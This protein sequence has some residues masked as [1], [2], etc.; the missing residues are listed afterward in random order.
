[1]WTF[2]RNQGGPSLAISALIHSVALA[3]LAFYKFSTYVA[4]ESVAVETV[5]ADERSQQQFDQDLSIDTRVSTSLST[6]SGG[7]VTTSIGSAATQA[8]GQAKIASSEVMK[9][10]ALSVATI[11][12]ISIPGVGELGMDLGEGEVKGE[13]G[14]RV[15]GYGAAMGRMT[16]ELFR[17]MRKEPVTV[18]WLFDASIS[19][20]DDRKE[21]SANFNKIYEELRIAQTEAKSRNMKVSPLDTMICSFGADVKKLLPGPTGDIAAIQKAIASVSDDESGKENT[22]AAI[23]KTLDEYGPGTSR[24]KRKLILIVVT[25]ET[26]D[27]DNL[28]EDAVAK[29]EKFKSPVYFMGREAIFG[30]PYAHVLWVDPATGL[31]HWPRVDR[32]PETEFPECLQYDGL[33]GRWDSAS[34]GFGPYGQVRLAKESGGIFFMLSGEEKDLV[35]RDAQGNR[36][37]DDLAMKEYEPLL[38]SRRQYETQRGKSEFR[39]TIWQVIVALN[40]HLD[41]ELNLRRDHWSMD[42][43]EFLKQKQTNFSRC[44]RALAKLNEGI[45]ILEKVEPLRA[46]ETEPRWRAAYDLAYAQLLCYRVRQFQYLLT[47]NLHER[48]NPNPSNPKSNV[49][50]LHNVQEML[51]PSEEEVKA[52]KVDMAELEKQKAKA[53]EL[54]D[55]VIKNHPGTPWARRAEQEKGWGFGFRLADHFHDPRYYDGTAKVEVPKF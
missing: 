50:N 10:P 35:G 55:E 3:A 13:T 52:S 29:S 25:D 43:A 33:G 30:Y 28:L 9:G 41:G 27:D 23:I 45:R 17:V 24:E 53:L 34:S 12:D 26:G 44:L 18:V 22:Y 37:Y 11:G 40:P 4:P 7:M 54:Y 32:G 21:I 46:K 15:E 5:I 39:K 1:M 8:V 49:W 16:Q 42:K 14:A 51:A 19:L 38:V 48:E 20:R 31:P 2:V 36:K 6:Q 47:L